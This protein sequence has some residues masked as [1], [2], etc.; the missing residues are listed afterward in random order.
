MINFMF[1]L[2]PGNPKMIHSKIKLSMVMSNPVNLFHH[3]AH[4]RFRFRLL[5][6]QAAVEKTI[7]VSN[8][9]FIQ[10]LLLVTQVAVENAITVDI[11]HLYKYKYY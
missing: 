2:L 8:H 11:T 9:S 4:V 5:A 6:K 1:W 3:R 10:L 7:S